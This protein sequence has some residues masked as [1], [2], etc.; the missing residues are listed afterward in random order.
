MCS[1]VETVT[2]VAFTVSAGT[3]DPAEVR[4]ARY[5]QALLGAEMLA[6]QLRRYAQETSRSAGAKRR[7]GAQPSAP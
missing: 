7:E 5:W 3:E 1:T 6:E 4:S 2:S